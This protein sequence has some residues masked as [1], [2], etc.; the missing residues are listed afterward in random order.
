MWPALLE[1]HLDGHDGSAVS[2]QFV[3][4]L[5]F[6]QQ[7]RDVRIEA[8][9]PNT[10]ASTARYLLAKLPLLRSLGLSLPTSDPI[11]AV[12]V[13]DIAGV[14][15]SRLENLSLVMPGSKD[16]PSPLMNLHL[17]CL[18]YLSLDGGSARGDAFTAFPT[19]TELQLGE[20]EPPNR[21]HF[22]LASCD[23][24]RFKAL[25][26]LHLHC[27]LKASSLLDA[28]KALPQLREL[29]VECDPPEHP[30]PSTFLVA[31]A[32]TRH[33]SL[34]TLDIYGLEFPVSRCEVLLGPSLP[35]LRLVFLQAGHSH[36]HMDD[37][38]YDRLLELA[39]SRGVRFVGL[40]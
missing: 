34:E 19:L 12:R 33:P 9:R 35:R 25:T 37:E 39:A 29:S 4:G 23:W 14:V 11:D 5:P 15:E 10:V 6:W 28:V 26:S 2:G 24:S 22:D 16:E 7:L 32:L 18:S 3:V 1:L 38:D 36:F 8:P 31:L 21:L 27:D 17:P 30:L 40:T 13:P 20:A